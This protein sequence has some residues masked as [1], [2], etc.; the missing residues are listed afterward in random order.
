M[1]STFVIALEILIKSALRKETSYDKIFALGEVKGVIEMYSKLSQL[2]DY[3][4]E[5]LIKEV[6][7]AKYMV[8][9]SNKEVE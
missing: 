9:N 7:L 3:E 1:K 8:I 2:H 6:N 4:Y 5:L